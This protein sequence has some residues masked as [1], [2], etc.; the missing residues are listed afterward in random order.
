MSRL[1]AFDHG[2][3]RIGVAVADSEAGIAFA[4]PALRERAA[5]D[6]AAALALIQA[7][8]AETVVVGLPRNMDGSE[9]PQAARA[10][11]FGAALEEVG[12][13]V[14][15]VDERLSSWRAREHMKEARRQPSRA[16]GELDS[17]AARLILQDYLDA[18]RAPERGGAPQEQESR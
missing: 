14:R 7:E 15:Y 18:G 1:I 11:A 12:M 5:R 10:R 6:R 13:I 3:R 9:G 16:S 4:R 2:T 17:A 8:G